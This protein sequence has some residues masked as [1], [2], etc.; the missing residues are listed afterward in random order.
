MAPTIEF[1]CD[2]CKKSFSTRKMIRQHLRRGCK[3]DKAFK[4]QECKQSFTR[5]A[6]L[7][8]HLVRHSSERTFICEVCRKT[9]KRKGSL[10]WH[11]R[12]HTN[13]E[14]YPC[15]RE[16][17]ATFTKP[18]DMKRH[19]ATIHEHRFRFKCPDCRRGFNSSRA[20]TS[21]RSSQH[22]L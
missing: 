19:V 6:Q 17:G 18:S 16:C 9:F 14:R 21:H 10:T 3:G 4:C 13:S 1:V 8:Q 5:M 2:K 20:L 12:S 11:S 22:N 15:S 7:K